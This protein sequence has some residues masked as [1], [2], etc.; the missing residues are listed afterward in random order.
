MERPA[1]YFFEVTEQ[2]TFIIFYTN[3]RSK[4]PF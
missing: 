1:E 4:K 3:K 2:G